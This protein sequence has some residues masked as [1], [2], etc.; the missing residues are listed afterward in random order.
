MLHSFSPQ[1]KSLLTSLL[2]KD[3][4]PFSLILQ[5]EKRLSIED[6]Q[7][8]EFFKDLSWGELLQRKV[9]PRF[10]PSVSS[11]TDTKNID[12]VSSFNSFKT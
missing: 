6:I 2:E 12:I 5:P 1:A 4:I 3:V 8:H 7:Q 9:I 11:E 10:I